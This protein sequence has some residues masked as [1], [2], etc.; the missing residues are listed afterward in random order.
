L[1]PKV[2][3]KVGIFIYDAGGRLSRAID[4]AEVV[5]RL[6]KA[7]N[8]TRRE[9]FNNLETPDPISSIQEDLRAGRLNRILWVGRFPDARRRRIEGELAAAGLNPYLQEWCD[10]EEQ[11]IGRGDFD[12]AVQAQKAIILIQMALARTRLLAPLMPLEIPAVDAALIIGGGVTGLHTAASLADLGKKVFLIEKESGVGGK[13]AALRRLYPLI[14]DPHCGLEFAL[15]KLE[16]S[17]RVE[18]H[19]LTRVKTLAGSPGNFSVRVEKQ[20]RYVD[21]QKC[22]ACGECITACPKE[23]QAGN[24]FPLAGDFS[25]RGQQVWN[26]NGLEKAIHQARPLAY[27][28]TYVIERQHCPPECRECQKACPT[29]AVEL[30]QT[31]SELEFKAGAVL[32]ATGWDPYPLTRV[33]EYGY[34]VYPNVVTNLE[35]EHI[36]EE[37]PDLQEVGFIQCAGSRDERYL[38]YCS[39]V[40]CSITLKQVLHLKEKRPGV[41]C[42]IFYQDIRTSG[43]DEELYQRVKSLDQ[44][45]FIRGDPATVKPE[46]NGR[47][48]V[49][50]EDTFSG[51]ELDLHLDLLVLAGGMVPSEGSRELAHLLKLPQN[52]YGFFEAHLPCHPEESQRTGIRAG[53]ACRG[54]MNVVHSIES[55]HRAAFDVLPFLSGTVRLEPT[56]PVLNL[57]KCDKCKRC[58]EECPYASFYFDGNGFPVPDLAK[59]RQCGNCVGSCP[60][61]AVSLGHFTVQ[62]VAS[63]IQAIKSG[64]LGKEEPV[65][66]AFLCKNDAYPAAKGAAE[67]GLPIPPNV[68]FIKVPCAGSINNAFIADALGFGIDGVL[69]AG[70]QDDQ[71]HYVKGNQLVKTRKENL[72]EKLQKMVIEPQ[73][74]RF[75]SLEIRD[76]RRY[77]DLVTSY[78]AELKK[79]GPNPFKT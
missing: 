73:R 53:G 34:G 66:L 46:E 31:A 17:G 67:S 60:L 38:N 13:V 33:E 5:Q 22:I 76:S 2:I 20:P 14:C 71:C 65:V 26:P 54:P 18:I 74:V 7:K 11:G 25:N 36:S 6:A 23:I 42:Y 61:F 78:I 45:I 79:M 75:E 32:I 29:R 77:V 49:R 44:V 30:E 68:F 40:C 15:Q 19:T 28:S 50:A 56:Y 57:T 51:K 52:S 63:Q 16:K 72:A 69:I 43:F 37:P 64:F 8:V 47:L 4:L 10:L 1:I 27:P 9:V 70:C 55:G 3:P 24:T 12:R 35:M 62:Q 59:C 21:E 41:R 39:S 48:R 58:M